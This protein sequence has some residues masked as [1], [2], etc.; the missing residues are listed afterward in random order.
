[1]S[2]AASNAPTQKL[3]LAKRA[4]EDMLERMRR[5]HNR[6]HLSHTHRIMAIRNVSLGM[7]TPCTRPVERF[8]DI[9]AY[10]ILGG[11]HHR[12]ARI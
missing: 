7:D 9:V 4:V 1:M 10:P 12:Y 6:D 2:P 11:L 5:E 3:A 8:E